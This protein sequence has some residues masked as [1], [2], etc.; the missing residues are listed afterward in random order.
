MKEAGIFIVSVF[1]KVYDYF[2][3][4][5]RA[6]HAHDSA[7]FI[8][9]RS[10]TL[11]SYLE[12]TLLSFVADVS[13]SHGNDVWDVYGLKSRA[14]EDTISQ[15]YLMI[16]IR[17]ADLMDVANDRVNYHL[18]RQNLTHLSPTS[19]FHW[20]SH[21]VTDRMDLKATYDI[22]KKEDGRLLEKRITETLNFDLHLNFQQLTTIANTQKCKCR[23]CSLSDH[24]ITIHIYSEKPYKT[25]DENSCTILCLWMTKKHEWLIQELTALNEYLF[26]VDNQMFKTCT[27]LNIYYRNDMKLDPDMFDSVQEYLDIVF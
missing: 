11:L 2:E 3:N 25:C 22:S 10:N 6:N 7:K 24:C 19:K 17:L 13:E 27:N 18:L 1:N 23:K 4:E 8:R 26:S 5:V 20:I 14:K 12:P 9:E 21:L 16:L 15:K